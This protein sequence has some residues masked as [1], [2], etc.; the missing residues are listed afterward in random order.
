M[1]SNGSAAG[2]PPAEAGTGSAP[3]T[4]VTTG[5]WSHRASSPASTSKGTGSD[6]VLTDVTARGA[7]A[8]ASATRTPAD[9]RSTGRVAR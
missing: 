6:P 7:S 8:M 3:G 1:T 2:V 4:G 5:A 9:S